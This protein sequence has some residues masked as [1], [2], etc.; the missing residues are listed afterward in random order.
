VNNEV[1]EGDAM[2]WLSKKIRDLLRA[3]DGLVAVEWIALTASMLVAAV[4]VAVLMNE[5]TLNRSS[6]IDAE[7]V[8]TT[9]AG[10]GAAG[11]E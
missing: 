5:N 7:I 10:G 3:D 11:T 1:E 6:P 2:N 8:R 4:A 9:N